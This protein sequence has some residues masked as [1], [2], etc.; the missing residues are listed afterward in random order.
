MIQGINSGKVLMPLGDQVLECMVMRFIGIRTA[1]QPYTGREYAVVGVADENV[2][3]IV[4]LMVANAQRLF[5]ER[6]RGVRLVKGSDSDSRHQDA[7][8]GQ[9]EPKPGV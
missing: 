7:P 5:P 6:M 2:L 9:P 8:V 4:E 3:D 1:H